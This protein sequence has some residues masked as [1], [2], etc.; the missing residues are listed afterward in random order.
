[1][2]LLWVNFCNGFLKEFRIFYYKYKQKVGRGGGGGG[3]KEGVLIYSKLKGDE[4][5]LISSL[6]WSVVP[7]NFPR[8]ECNYLKIKM[9]EEKLGDSSL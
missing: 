7:P 1:M 4:C 6:E 3:R 2:F 9:E 8:E 5:F